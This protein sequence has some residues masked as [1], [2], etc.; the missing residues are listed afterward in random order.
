MWPRNICVIDLALLQNAVLG[1]RFDDGDRVASTGD[2]EAKRASGAVQ[3]TC[4][5]TPVTCSLCPVT[6]DTASITTCRKQSLIQV[7]TTT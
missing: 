6:S 1:D 2:S 5:L 4:P 7:Y 3:E